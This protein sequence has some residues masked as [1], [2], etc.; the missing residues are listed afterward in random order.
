MRSQRP[1]NTAKLWQRA[2]IISNSF[3]RN[4]G[5]WIPTFL[6]LWQEEILFLIA[7]VWLSCGFLYGIY[8][9]YL[10]KISSLTWKSWK[11]FRLSI[12]HDINRNNR[13]TLFGQVEINKREKEEGEEVRIRRKR[14]GAITEREQSR[15]WGTGEMV[16]SRAID[17]FR[18]GRRKMR[19]ANKS[20]EC[21]TVSLHI[22]CRFFHHFNISKSYECFE[23]NTRGN[24]SS[25]LIIITI[26]SW[27]RT[28]HREKWNV[29]DSSLALICAY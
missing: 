9:N 20:W 13:A 6:F 16:Y 28:P 26:R 24:I 22:Y 5:F 21:L 11:N 14:E 25:I 15:L 4:Y 12:L 18:S 10:P 23:R 17:P 3:I 2:A 19:N 27:V 1:K 29:C 7:R 8:N